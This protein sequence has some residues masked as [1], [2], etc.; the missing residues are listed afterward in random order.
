MTVELKRERGTKQRS[1]KL[2]EVSFF[3]IVRFFG[4]GYFCSRVLC[5]NPLYLV[6]SGLKK[7]TRIIR[8]TLVA[9]I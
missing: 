5:K 4:Y 3:I 8:I 1:V 9:H 2:S 7:K 6:E